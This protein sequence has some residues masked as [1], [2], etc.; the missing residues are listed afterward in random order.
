MKCL[1]YSFPLSI[2][3][4]C[5]VRTLATN[6]PWLGTITESVFSSGPTLKHW[7][8]VD[9]SVVNWERF[10]WV[11]VGVEQPLL[12]NLRKLKK[13]MSLLQKILWEE[14][15]HW[16]ERKDIPRD[17]FLATSTAWGSMARVSSD[18]NVKTLG[19]LIWEESSIPGSI[20]IQNIM[21]FISELCWT[22]MS[23]LVRKTVE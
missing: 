1:P 17:V 14:K 10:D 9:M 18:A 5:L 2:L 13:E 16:S 4:S 19:H 15:F 21:L 8:E 20:V 7:I 12:C 23:S 3:C 11:E 22:F 6:C